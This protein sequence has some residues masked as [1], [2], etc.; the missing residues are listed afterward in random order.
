MLMIGQAIEKG[1]QTVSNTDSQS[2]LTFIDGFSF[3]VYASVGFKQQAILAAERCARA[4]EF[5]SNLFSCKLRFQL[6]ILASRDWVSHTDQPT[7]G[8]PHFN[9]LEQRLILASEPSD[10]WRGFAEIIRASSLESY[11]ELQSVYG[12]EG[13][14]VDLSPFFN[15]LAV[16]EL[17]HGFH[18]QGLCD[19]PR[20][21]LMEFFCNLC[22]HAYIASIEPEQL[23]ILETAPRLIAKVDN[24]GL[25]HRTLADFEMLYT[26]MDP[27]N[28]GWYQAHFH[29][30]AKQIYDTA[31]VEVLKALWQTFVMPDALVVDKLRQQVHPSV[32]NIMTMWSGKQMG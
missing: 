25:K 13:G 30:A 32:A 14:Q 17:A 26:N 28:Y 20:Y 1:T 2:D 16:H 15:L 29:V 9:F 10:F 12:Q 27:Q 23:P 7:Y 24:I 3:P 8:M 22:L 6:Q 21:W 11:H 5:M 31:G 18:H 4:Y 19:F